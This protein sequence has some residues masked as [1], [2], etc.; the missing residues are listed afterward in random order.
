MSARRPAVAVYA[1][2]SNGDGLHTPT[3]LVQEA[4]RRRY[5]VL[6]AVADTGTGLPL[7][8]R[9]GWERLRPLLGCGRLLVASAGELAPDA[10]LQPVLRLL[11]ASAVVV[12]ETRS[13][14]PRRPRTPRH[15][16]PRTA[17]PLCH[18]TFPAAPAQ[19][20][21]A[22]EVTRGFLTW[23]TPSRQGTALVEAVEEAVGQAITHPPSPEA[24]VAV[25]LATRA[26]VIHTDVAG[27][28]A[29]PLSVPRTIRIP[30]ALRQHYE[31]GPGRTLTVRMQFPATRD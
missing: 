15:E 13:P 31:L 24:P 8:R 3:D 26:G 29:R 14:R 2:A 9:S 17:G 16:P 27:H 11:K 22:P 21:P 23:G 6:G 30:G 20:E 5:R 4:A 25:T 10:Q 28:F 12:E 7:D 19:L 1:C 18:V